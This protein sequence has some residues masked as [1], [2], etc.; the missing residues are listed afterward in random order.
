MIC[1]TQP[2]K[3]DFAR[4]K[5]MLANGMSYK[6]IADALGRTPDAVKQKFVYENNRGNK[7]R[8]K[9][10]TAQNFERM[11]EMLLQGKTY[12]QIGESFGIS[13]HAVYDIFR[14]RKHHG[15]SGKPRKTITHG[16]YGAYIKKL[17]QVPDHIVKKF[18]KDEPL[19]DAEFAEYQAAIQ[20][21][22]RRY[23]ELLQAGEITP[24]VQR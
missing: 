13:K 19:T 12:Q 8:A 7:P 14:R 18:A 11:R 5:Q 20:S 10:W 23:I 9:E 6:E 3:A 17:P 1:G 2:W 21:V 4:A 22:D 24:R 15:E 16:D